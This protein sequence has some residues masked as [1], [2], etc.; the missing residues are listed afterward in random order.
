M[1]MHY[2]IFFAYFLQASI[3]CIYRYIYI[4]FVDPTALC[5]PHSTSPESCNDVFH[6]LVSVRCRYIMCTACAYAGH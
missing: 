2:D 1:N 5:S 4:H 6:I 3:I